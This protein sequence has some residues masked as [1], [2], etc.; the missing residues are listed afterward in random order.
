VTNGTDHPGGD[1]L[2][3]GQ[4]AHK[5]RGRG[6]QGFAYAELVDLSTGI[7]HQAP[8]EPWK[9]SIRPIRHGV[10]GLS[11][12]EE[13]FGVSASQLTPSSGLGPAF[14]EVTAITHTGTHVDAPWHYGPVSGGDPAKT[15]EQCPLEWFF[16]DGVVLD[17]RHKE[18]GDRISVADLEGCLADIEYT[19]KPLDIVMLMTGCDKRLGSSEYFRQPGMT[20]ESTLWLLEQGIKVVGIDAYGFDRSFDDMAAE[21][22]RTGDAT[23]IWEA[24]FAGL[25]REYCQIEKL[26]NLDKVSRPC[27]F[28]VACFPIK[29]EGG[30][31]GWSRVV[32]FV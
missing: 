16:S 13:S 18:A 26:V 23:K 28:K 2:A 11:W 24:H 20:R 1:E 14:E 12:M 5:A 10:E 4:A 9:P 22:A 27:N 30:S 19:L 29:V 31:A 15:I 8:H 17:L 32:A 25:E 21:F 7:E 3:L 6:S